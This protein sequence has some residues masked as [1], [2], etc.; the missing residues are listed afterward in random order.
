MFSGYY[1]LATILTNP[2]FIAIGFIIAIGYFWG[3]SEIYNDLLFEHM[4]D[5]R[6]KATLI[7]VRSQFANIFQIIIAS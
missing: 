5:P 3:R 7:S 2:F 6:Y 1:L 4:K